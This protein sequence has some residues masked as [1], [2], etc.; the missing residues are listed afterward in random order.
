[1]VRDLHPGR[2]HLYEPISVNIQIENVAFKVL[3]LG[4]G[5]NGVASQVERYNRLA[6]ER[7]GSGQRQKVTSHS[8]LGERSGPHS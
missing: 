7:Q 3:S 6:C 4:V 2:V 8:A 5:V 1:M